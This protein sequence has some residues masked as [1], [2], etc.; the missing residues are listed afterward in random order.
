MED[1]DA[2]VSNDLVIAICLLNM[3][4]TP[5]ANLAFNG[6]APMLTSFM[7]EVYASQLWLRTNSLN[8]M[9]TP[10]PHSDCMAMDVL[11][12]E[13]V[14]HLGGPK[15]ATVQLSTATVSVPPNH[16][17]SDGQEGEVGAGDGTTKSVLHVSPHITF[18]C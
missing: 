12:D 9:H 14:C 8:L 13:I 11:Q 16:A 4:P 1:A 15:A 18:S 2:P 5:L 7:P 10:P 3:I 17:Y 6:A